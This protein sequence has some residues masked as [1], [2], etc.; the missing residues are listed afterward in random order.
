[1]GTKKVLN[2]YLRR[3]ADEI[4]HLYLKTRLGLEDFR[5]RSVEGITKY[6]TLTFL[7]LAYL[8]WR[9]GSMPS[10]DEKKLSEMI[11]EHRTGHLLKALDHFGQEVLR[12]QSVDDALK[13]FFPEIV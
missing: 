8:Y 12:L 4:D 6:L 3:W 9:R 13:T 11:S 1:L 7:S 10:P 5:I 2:R